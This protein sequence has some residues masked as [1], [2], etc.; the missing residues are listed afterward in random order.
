MNY[1]KYIY[2]SYGE[3]FGTINSIASPADRVK[4]NKT[5]VWHTRNWLPDDKG[6]AIID[7]GCGT[8]EDL[9][10]YISQGYSNV[11]GVDISPSQLHH[12]EKL[13][14]KTKE[15]DM[16][17]FLKGND[18]SFDVISAYDVIEHLTKDDVLD[19]LYLTLDSL[20]DGGTLILR[21]PNAASLFASNLRYGDFTH[22]LSFTPE[23]LVLLMKAAGFKE[24]ET[25]EASPI[26]L[27]YSIFSTIRFLLWRLVRLCI[28][29]INLIETGSTGDDVYSRVFL[30]KGRKND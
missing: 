4:K 10:F 13:D 19:F 16:L 30:V 11:L 25:R 6:S 9:A 22:E 23:C 7:L 21:T 14:V 18:D 17:D 24:I 5:Q 28:K 3:N 15:A 20:N 26:P 8:G 12:A 29:S 2:Q 1:S 27:G